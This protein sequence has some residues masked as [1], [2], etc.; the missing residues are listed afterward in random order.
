[1]RADVGERAPQARL[2]AGVEDEADGAARADAALGEGAEEARGVEDE[3]DVAAVVERA[4]AEVPAV[5]VR[6]EDD[7]LVGL[8]AAAHLGDDVARGHARRGVGGDGEAHAHLDAGGE[9]ARQTQAAFALDEG[10]RRRRHHAC[11]RA[12]R[13]DDRGGGSDGSRGRGRRRRRPA[14]A[15]DERRRLEVLLEEIVHRAHRIGV[16]EREAAGERAGGGDGGGVTV[17]D[18]DDVGFEAARRRVRRERHGGDAEERAP[19]G[20]GWGDELGALLARQPQARR[21]VAL[22]AR[23]IDAGGA[24]A[25]EPPVDGA[26][27][28]GAARRT[29]TDGVGERA[30]ILDDGGRGESA[31]DELVVRRGGGFGKGQR[32]RGGNDAAGETR[33]DGAGDDQAGGSHPPIL[34][35][36]RDHLKSPRQMSKRTPHQAS[37]SVHRRSAAAGSMAHGRTP[38]RRRRHRRRQ[39]RRCRHPRSRRR[40]CRRAADAWRTRRSSRRPAPRSCRRCRS[41]GR[42]G[43]AARMASSSLRD[44]AADELGD[45]GAGMHGEGAHAVRL[46]RARRARRRRARSPTSPGRRRPTCRRGGARTADRRSRRRRDVPARR[47]RRRR[48]RRAAARSA[49]HSRAVSWKWPRWLVASCDSKPRA[50][51]A[52]GVAMMPALS[53]RM[54]SGRPDADEARGE[55][56]DRRG[57]AQVERLDLDARDAGEATRALSSV[58]APHDDGRAGPGERA[59]GLEPDAGVAA[60]H[61]GHAAVEVAAG[62]HFAGGGAL[63]VS[64]RDRRLR[65]LH[66]RTVAAAGPR[67]ANPARQ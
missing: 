40:P 7:D 48:A 12:W 10:G 22:G 29:A 20:G 23:V 8:V 17:T 4:A 14:Q 27:E 41:R 65:G 9:Q 46:R 18:V 2:L 25:R 50:S 39:R 15:I 37:L 24:E 56:V 64:G 63:G 28:R 61:D 55:R 44:R 52:S 13:C 42:R 47:Q 35:R 45:D 3:R 1:M 21:F 67:V 11:R 16:H 60:G 58:R 43:V 19:A 33:R 53:T 6:A 66:A 59:G 36:A 31:R 54:C 5:E 32:S 34:S 62:E 49:G 51:R 30:Q 38:R 26:L 57:I